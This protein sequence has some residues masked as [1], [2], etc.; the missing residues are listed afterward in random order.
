MTQPPQNDISRLIGL[1]LIV[2]SVVWMVTV[3]LCSGAF[4]V[5]LLAEGNVSDLSAVLLIGI[6]AGL[7]GGVL[8]LIG[9]WLRPR[10][11]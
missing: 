9:R 5:G 4:I 7:I 8:Y 10:Q 11:D 1:F 2:L 6:P 3:G